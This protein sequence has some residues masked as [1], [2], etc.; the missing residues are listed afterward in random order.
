[1]RA[2]KRYAGLAGGF[3]AI[4]LGYAL[5]GSGDV[6]VAPLLLVLG[7]C[8]LIPMFLLQSFL[9]GKGE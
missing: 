9:E 2:L 3:V 8:L 7:Y 1:M 6:T 4:V 5:L